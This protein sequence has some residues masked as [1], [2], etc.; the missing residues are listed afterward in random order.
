MILDRVTCGEEEGVFIRE[1]LFYT[2]V[3]FYYV[4][5]CIVFAWELGMPRRRLAVIIPGSFSYVGLWDLLCLYV[6]M[7]FHTFLFIVL[8][9]GKYIWGRQMG[10]LWICNLVSFSRIGK[11]AW[12]VIYRYT[13]KIRK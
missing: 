4:C 10:Q 3:L 5:L 7:T 2:R 11:G 13:G 12:A 1:F 8:P 9:V 6:G